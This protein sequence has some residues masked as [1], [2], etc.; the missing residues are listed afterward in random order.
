MKNELDI[1]QSIFV[2]YKRGF[3]L[4]DKY[5]YLLQ[6]YQ[7]LQDNKV[8][9]IGKFLDDVKHAILIDDQHKVLR[10]LCQTLTIRGRNYNESPLVVYKGFDAEESFVMFLYFNDIKGILDNNLSDDRTTFCETLENKMLTSIRK[11]KCLNKRQQSFDRY[12]TVIF[13]HI[14]QCRELPSEK[15]IPLLQNMVQNIPKDL[16]D[17]YARLVYQSKMASTYVYADELQKAESFVDDTLRV[18]S[19]CENP[20]YQVIAY[21]DC[22][23]VYRCLFTKTHDLRYID[24]TAKMFRKAM[25]ILSEDV[26]HELSLWG[27]LLLLHMALAY[28][29]VDIFLGIPRLEIPEAYILSAQQILV[30]LKGRVKVSRRREMFLNLGFARFYELEAE[31]EIAVVYCCLA[32]NQADD[33]AYFK[34]DRE[35]IEV[36]LNRLVAQVLPKPNLF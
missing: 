36:Y 27:T 31:Y 6:K 11:N 24:K 4:K 15:R 16:D 32:L 28:L 23:V 2:L 25:D 17:S 19:R 13:L 3:L 21:Y 18:L 26:I 20:F 1:L 30:H 14:Q 29:G 35:N 7:C 22:L 8:D 9:D 5:R 33:G 12:I 34:L 10:L